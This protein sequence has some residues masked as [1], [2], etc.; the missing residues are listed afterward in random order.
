MR[1]YLAIIKDSFREALSSRVLWILLVLSTL[2][3]AAVAP[4]GIKEQAGA[5]FGPNEI[6]DARGL[7]DKIKQQQAAAPPSPGKQIWPLLDAEFRNR[8]SEP[9]SAASPWQGA[10]YNRLDGEL[11]HVLGSREL[12]DAA[13]WADVPLPDE[14]R[15][16]IDRGV[17]RLADDELWRLNRLLLEAAY[18]DHITRSRTP[19]VLVTYLWFH[20]IDPLTVPKKALIDNSINAFVW[21]FVGVVGVFAGVLVTAS[22]IPQTYTAGAIDLLLSKPISRSLLFLSKYLGGCMF[23]LINAGYLVVGLWLIAGLR[24]GQWSN[25]LLISIP[26]FLFVFAIYYA[27]SALAGAIWR[28]AIVCVVMTVLLWAA[29]FVVG[30]AKVGLDAFLSVTQQLAKL[31]PAGNDLVAA[32]EMGQVLKWQPDEQKWSEIFTSGEPS[33][34]MMV[35]MVGPMIGPVYD[36]E[37]QRLLAVPSASGQFGV[38]SD[39]LQ[40]AARDD[41]WMRKDGVAAP[42]GT[43]ALFVT[44][45]HATL[46]VTPRGI[47]RLD[48]DAAA[49]TEQ[50][51]VLGFNLPVASRGSKFVAAGPSLRLNAPLSAAIDPANGD[52]ALFDSSDLIVLR[53]NAKGRYEERAK[54]AVE[55]NLAGIVSTAGGT[56]LLGRADGRITVFEG[57]ESNPTNELR[58][59]GNSAPRS[60][61][62]SADGK[63]FAVVFHNRKLW[64]YDVAGRRTCQTPITGQG[65]ISA[66][67]F[68]GNRLLVADH[69]NRVTKY[70]LPT[71]EVVERYR[72]SLG[73]LQTAYFYALKPI[74]TVFPKPGEIDNVVTYLL[75]ESDTAPMGNNLNDL[76]SP[77]VKIDVWGPIWSN[78]A[79]I[80]V[81]VG[82]GCWY[83]QRKDF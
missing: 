33:Q 14:A 74:Y 56:V 19:S 26:V 49:R 80:A 1:A 71:G 29:C 54:R 4:I 37:H 77:R 21:F 12:Y 25:K 31:I 43:A 16:L 79:F 65:T 15:L 10:V 13:A 46:A 9:P 35:G 51:K 17:E 67:A 40:V 24:W 57:P 39:A 34:P 45:R 82:L 70:A 42:A 68:D 22:I 55:G 64:I 36:G 27:V 60:I 20:P 47:F 66:A 7:L 61:E 62:A 5:R 73:V 53:P 8:I 6:I 18:P 11:N 50:I 48:G 59:E 44:P 76:R 63:F 28:N 58:P 69:F 72:P 52:L 41:G 83:T 30:Q 32:N 38:Q 3:L 78:L 2:V 23:I 75:N 81:V